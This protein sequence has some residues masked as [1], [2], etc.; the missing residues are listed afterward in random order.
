VSGTDV[1]E[2]F[3]HRWIGSSVP[4]ISPTHHR[5]IGFDGASVMGFVVLPADRDLRKQKGKN[6][7]L[8]KVKDKN[9][10]TRFQAGP[11]K[12]KDRGGR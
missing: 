11:D 6:V 8:S 1:F 12:S 4:T 5:T 2:F 9:G 7:S 10:R 3:P